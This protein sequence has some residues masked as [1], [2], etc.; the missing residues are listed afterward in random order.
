MSNS[1]PDAKEISKMARRFITYSLE[2]AHEDVQQLSNVEVSDL[3]GVV[4]YSGIHPN[5]GSVHIVIPAMGES[6]LLLP[7]VFQDF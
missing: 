6:L 4:H 1:K 2:Q 3:G 7:F 5:Y